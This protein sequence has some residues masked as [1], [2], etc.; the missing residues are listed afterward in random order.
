MSETTNSRDFVEE[1]GLRENN[2][3]NGHIKRAVE[4]QERKTEGVID[5]YVSKKWYKGPL[6]SAREVK[7]RLTSLR[8]IQQRAIA[9]KDEEIRKLEDALQG[10]EVKKVRAPLPHMIDNL[11]RG[12]HTKKNIADGILR[13]LV[14]VNVTAL[15]PG[16]QRLPE[17]NPIA[18]G[19]IVHAIHELQGLYNHQLKDKNILIRKLRKD[20]KEKNKE[21]AETIKRKKKERKESVKREKEDRKAEAQL[22]KLDKQRYDLIMKKLRNKKSGQGYQPGDQPNQ[23]AANDTNFD[24]NLPEEPKQDAA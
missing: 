23:Y 15:T 24:E 14:P 5:E 11:K 17:L 9:T 7:S 12:Y 21:R 10:D 13:I 6:S 4:E 18:Y 20:L 16:L 19:K 1:E 2:I 8:E 3:Q 22:R